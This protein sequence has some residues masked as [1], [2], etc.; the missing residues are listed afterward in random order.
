MTSLNHLSELQRG[1]FVA[2]FK[3]LITSGKTNKIVIKL[4]DES[5]GNY[6]P[7]TEV[8]VL[9]TAQSLM[10]TVAEVNNVIDAIRYLSI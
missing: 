6:L 9:E 7:T 4:L 2:L 8:E 10:K 3:Y 1:D 5:L